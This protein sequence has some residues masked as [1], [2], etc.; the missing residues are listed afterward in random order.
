MIEAGQMEA[1][2]ESIGEHA[3]GVRLDRV[4]GSW[5]SFY[6]DKVVPAWLALGR[7]EEA[8]E[9]ARA[10]EAVAEATG[11]PLADA[12]AR[13]L[14]ARLA[15]GADAAELALASSVIFDASGAPVEAAISRT[16]AGTA[17]AA[18]GETARATD[19]LTD[20]SLTLERHG[21][22]R[23]R[24]AAERELGRLGRRRHRRTRAGAADGQGIDSLTERELQV[25]QLIVDRRTNAE[26]AATLFLSQKTVETHVRNLFHKLGVSSRVDVARVVER[27]N[28]GG[29]QG[30]APM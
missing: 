11:V 13:R 12:S 21:A 14:R 15:D 3:G 20:A 22:L 7:R 2:L 17:L 29:R 18:A 27:A 24:D 10:A 26:I 9:A 16:L 1:A 8:E 6:L 4:P 23:Y 28:P 5:R 19:L 30:R 25:A